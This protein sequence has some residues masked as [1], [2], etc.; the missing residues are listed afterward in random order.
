M[1]KVP[2]SALTVSGRLSGSRSIGSD[3]G[4]GNRQFRWQVTAML[5]F[6][7]RHHIHGRVPAGRTVGVHYVIVSDTD[8]LFVS[9]LEMVASTSVP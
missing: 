1:R 7:L 3:S 8:P 5:P 4:F 9:V 6:A 2:S